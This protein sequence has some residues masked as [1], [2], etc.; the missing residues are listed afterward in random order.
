MEPCNAVRLSQRPALQA[1]TLTPLSVLRRCSYCNMK[2]AG[3]GCR[4][5]SSYCRRQ[6]H[7]NCARKAG[8]V[9][10]PEEHLLACHKC[11]R[12]YKKQDPQR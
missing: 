7:L 12:M 1:L 5:E 9:F 4:T 6:Y 2:G 11:K 8:C 10:F 3:Y